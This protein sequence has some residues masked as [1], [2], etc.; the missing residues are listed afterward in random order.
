VQ[1][2]SGGVYRG[3]CSNELNHVVLIVGYGNDAIEGPYWIIKNSWGPLWGEKGYMR[4]AITSG[5]GT[6]GITR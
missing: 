2:Y 1:T 4:I 6:C 5:P 3:D